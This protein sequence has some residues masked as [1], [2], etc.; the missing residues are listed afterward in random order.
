MALKHTYT[1]MAPIYDVLVDRASRPNRQQS[2]KRFTNC[3]D[4]SVLIIGIGTGLDIPHLDERAR[5]TG[6]DITSAMLRKAKKR[7]CLR[8]E[9]TITL[10]QGDAQK[11][12]YDDNQFDMVLMHLILAVVPD[13]ISAFKEACRVL[14]PGGQLLILDKFLK[15]GQRAFGRRLVNLFVRHIA[16]K[17]DVIFEDL[18]DHVPHVSIVSDEPALAS[19]WF[20]YIELTK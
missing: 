3:E 9:L 17:T 6:I 1:A 19:G 2:L 4:K 11:L 8:P 5:Y 18:L 10:Q 20:R 16:T 13:S 12:L 15:R 7:A 14:K